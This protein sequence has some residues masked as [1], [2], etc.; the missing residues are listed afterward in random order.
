MMHAQEW[1][2][3]A[4]MQLKRYAES[5]YVI[6]TCPRFRACFRSR[7]RANLA[8]HKNTLNKAMAVFKG[9]TKAVLRIVAAEYSTAPATAQ[10]KQARLRSKRQDSCRHLT[11]L[12][13]TTALTQPP[14][15]QSSLLLRR[16]RYR[17]HHQLRMQPDDCRLTTRLSLARSFALHSF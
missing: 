16:Q 8:E 10:A 6:E 13:Q 5:F 1:R 7:L 17:C 11:K 3:G 9:I 14:S 2:E 4:E 15:D 12:S